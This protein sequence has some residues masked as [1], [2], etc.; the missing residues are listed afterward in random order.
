MRATRARDGTAGRSCESGWIDVEG[1]SGTA[2]IPEPAS[3]T[4]GAPLDSTA[5]VRTAQAAPLYHDRDVAHPAIRDPAVQ[6]GAP[7]GTHPT[8][9]AMAD[10]RVLV[11][12]TN[13]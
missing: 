13:L 9:D 6:A 1:Q 8:L 12:G 5:P 11:H 4:R 3:R 10:L 7:I 2:A